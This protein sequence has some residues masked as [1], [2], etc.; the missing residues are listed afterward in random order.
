MGGFFVRSIQL[1]LTRHPP[2]C[3]EDLT[4]PANR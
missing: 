4:Q 2:A 3:P 1:T